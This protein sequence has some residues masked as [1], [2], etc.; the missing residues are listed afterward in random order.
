A[1]VV[2]LGL[3]ACDGGSEAP[4]AGAGG[5]AKWFT[6]ERAEEYPGIA[7]VRGLKITMADGVELSASVALPADA[8]GNPVE[9]PFPVILTQT[10]YN[11]SIPE[12]PASNDYLVRRGYAHL[13]VDVRGTG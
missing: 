11:K 13:S 6:Y 12:I 1:A 10:G 2:V 3:A 7:T 5:D 9:Q 8:D 4:G